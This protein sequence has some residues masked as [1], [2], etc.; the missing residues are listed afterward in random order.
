MGF[1]FS[2]SHTLCFNL[3]RQMKVGATGGR[4]GGVR[5]RLG[6]GD[7]RSASPLTRLG[8]TKST[9][10]AN[11]QGCPTALPAG[12]DE[13]KMVGATVTASG[14]R[15]PA[16]VRRLLGEMGERRRR[17]DAGMVTGEAKRSETV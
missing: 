6:S 7:N 15:R 16:T 14:L 8:G 5:P 11:K 4:G 12:K 1:R 13:K 9:N 17:R 10:R 3:G 2:P